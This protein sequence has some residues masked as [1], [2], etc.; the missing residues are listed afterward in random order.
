MKKMLSLLGAIGLVATSS[1]TVVSCGDPAETTYELLS[2]KVEEIKTVLDAATDKDGV[3]QT[4]TYGQLFNMNNLK[5]GDEGYIS[6]LDEMFYTPI[7]N[8]WSTDEDNKAD[9]SE[10][11]TNWGH[12][13]L[14]LVELQHTKN[15]DG[16]KGEDK[17]LTTFSSNDKDSTLQDLYNSALP[18]H[19]PNDQEVYKSTTLAIKVSNNVG[20]VVLGQDYFLTFTFTPLV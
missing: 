11:L 18:E 5:V 19:E 3:D 20:G 1:A 16:S 12:D 10:E 17:V 13:A 15:E 7:N 9:L 8:I 4:I 14:T 6:T 2:G